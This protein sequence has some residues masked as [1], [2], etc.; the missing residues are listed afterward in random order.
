LC[1]RER[2]R[3]HFSALLLGWSIVRRGAERRFPSRVLYVVERVAPDAERACAFHGRLRSNPDRTTC[4]CRHVAKSHLLLTKP[5]AMPLLCGDR[6]GV[7]QA[8]MPRSRANSRVSRAMQPEPL[9]LSHCAGCGSCSTWPKRVLNVCNRTSCRVA[10]R[11]FVT[12]CLIGDVTEAL[13]VLTLATRSA[14][15]RLRRQQSARR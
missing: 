9:S 4:A 7:R 2:F 8:I 5:S 13:P 10:S 3:C 14:V 11:N 15:C 1:A 6:Y 12:G